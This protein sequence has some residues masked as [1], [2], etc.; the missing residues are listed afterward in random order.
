MADLTLIS[1]LKAVTSTFQRY[2][3]LVSAG[4]SFVRWSGVFFGFGL[5]GT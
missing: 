4:G 3:D 5:G 1:D 2:V